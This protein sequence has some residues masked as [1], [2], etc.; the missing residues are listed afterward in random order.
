MKKP[1]LLE[2]KQLEK[3]KEDFQEVLF[4]LKNYKPV[5]YKPNKE[6]LK[7]RNNILSSQ[8]KK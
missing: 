8:K 7:K 6:L 4:F 3:E 2:N 1:S 5:K